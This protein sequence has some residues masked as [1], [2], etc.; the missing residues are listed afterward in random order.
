MVGC[1]KLIQYIRMELGRFIFL[2]GS[3]GPS[4]IQMQ[5]LNFVKDCRK[6]TYIF[7]FTTVLW[8]CPHPRNND[9]ITKDHEKVT[10]LARDVLAEPNSR[11]KLND[12]SIKDCVSERL[13]YGLC[14]GRTEAAEAIRRCTPMKSRII[15]ITSRVRGV[16]NSFITSRT[17]W[18][19]WSRSSK[20]IP[21]SKSDLATS[22]L[23]QIAASCKAVPRAVRALMSKPAPKIKSTTPL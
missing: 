10:H 14:G 17:V 20:L 8:P 9:R 15:W 1:Q 16:F 19:S 13:S 3:V 2:R 4:K 5:I 11:S 22:N 7:F 21:A 23:P 12:S 18:S 6:L